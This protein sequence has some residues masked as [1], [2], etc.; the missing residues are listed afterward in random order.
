[1]EEAIGVIV[2]NY[3]YDRYLASTIAS[4]AGQSHEAVSL[5]VCDD[6]STDESWRRILEACAAHGS[7]FRRIEL[8]RSA[9]NL[10]KNAWINRVVPG[11]AESHL[12]ILDSDDTIPPDYLAALMGEL[13]RAAA[14]ASP[15]DFVYTDCRLIDPQGK[16]IGAGRSRAFDAALVE[17]FSYI[18]E[19]ALVATESLRRALPLDAS[20]RRGTKHDKYKRLVRLG[21]VGRHTDAT[22][23]N[24]RMHDDNLSGIG[25]RVRREIEAG[26]PGEERILSGYWPVSEVPAGL[27]A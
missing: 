27:P 16:V 25:V 13:R 2:C 12:V 24:Y 1:M 9:V 5:V 3:N 15:V 23:F 8:H 18:P 26:C 11:L 10:G 7:R 20:V 4:I 22:W 17:R 6:A 21:A 14:D 19:P